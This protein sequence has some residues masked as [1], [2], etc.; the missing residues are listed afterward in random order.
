M[1]IGVKC[2][3]WLIPQK[4]KTF[5]DVFKMFIRACFYQP[6]NFQMNLTAHCWVDATKLVFSLEILQFLVTIFNIITYKDKLLTAKKF[7]KVRSTQVYVT[8]N[9]KWSHRKLKT[10][11]HNLF[12]MFSNFKIFLWNYCIKFYQT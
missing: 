1:N 12:I 6:W 9:D 5:T 2:K 3:F 7:N 11:F 4:L 8:K 10:I